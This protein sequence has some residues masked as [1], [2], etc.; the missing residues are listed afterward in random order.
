MTKDI[1]DKCLELAETTVHSTATIVNTV[2]AASGILTDEQI[3]E[4]LNA[5][6]PFWLLNILTIHVSGGGVINEIKPFIRPT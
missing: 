2:K 1:I 5:S 4:C 6:D 3:L